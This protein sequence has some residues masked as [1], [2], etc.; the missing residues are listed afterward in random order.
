MEHRRLICER[1]LHKY[2][3][4]SEFR[5]LYDIARAE[6]EYQKDKFSLILAICN[7]KSN[8]AM[9]ECNKLNMFTNTPKQDDIQAWKKLEIRIDHETAEVYYDLSKFDQY[10]Y[11]PSK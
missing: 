11:Y 8:L 1:C 4:N 7:Y 9:P 3:N 6:W 2:N 5:E 10:S